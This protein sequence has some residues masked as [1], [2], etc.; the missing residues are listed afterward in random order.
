MICNNQ[1]FILA[2]YR[3]KDAAV[4]PLAG[5]LFVV[6]GAGGAGKALAYG[7]KE[8]GA[9]VI[10]AN[11]TYGKFIELLVIPLFKKLL[12]QVSMLYRSSCMSK[13]KTRLIMV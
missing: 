6:I 8:K 10:I 4:S 2:G 11:R 12:Y 9:K 5:H 13:S 3:V 7:A 1:R